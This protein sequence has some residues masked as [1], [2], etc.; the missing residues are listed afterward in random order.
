MRSTRIA[1]SAALLGA[2]A[3]PALSATTATAAPVSA[4][5]SAPAAGPCDRPGP[6]VIGTKAVTIRS[7]ASAASTSVGILYRG[8][9]F[10][11]HKTSGNWH[12]ITDTTTGVKG[13]VSGTYVYRSVHMCLD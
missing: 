4:P 12:Y 5:N 1:I 8:H 9:K 7:K 10:T 2:L 3:L 6:W 11:V 13:W